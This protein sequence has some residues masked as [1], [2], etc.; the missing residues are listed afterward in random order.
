MKQMRISA[1]LLLTVL[2]I[3][4]SAALNITNSSQTTQIGSTTNP[5]NA[6]MQGQ[7]SSESFKI[8]G[9][10]T[11][12]SH[13]NLI[14]YLLFIL[15]AFIIIV[16]ILKGADIFNQKWINSAISLIVVLLGVYSGT[17][18]RFLSSITEFGFQSTY[19]ALITPYIVL[20]IIATYLVI[21][22]FVKILKRNKGFDKENIE[23][24]GDK[25][26]TLKKIQDIEMKARGMK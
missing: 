1:I 5:I 13:Q 18:Y 14:I 21:R 24:Y 17:M 9:A 11:Q 6:F 2:L 23:E 16:D 4:F 8:I 22:I 26:K 3:N 19:L 20:A 15:I 25:M 7:I 12:L 10:P